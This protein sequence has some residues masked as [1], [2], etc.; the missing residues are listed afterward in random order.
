MRPLLILALALAGGLA[1]GHG[2]APAD[3]PANATPSGNTLQPRLEFASADTELL[4]V[5]Q[6]PHALQIY[7]DDF[8]SNA[9]VDDATLII[10]AGP[11]QRV[12]A[13]AQKAGE[14]LADAEWL[15]G[16]GKLALQL[17]LESPT[18]LE[19]WRGELDLRAP[20]A[21][22]ADIPEHSHRTLL[23]A[24]LL[25]VLLVGTLTWR[26]GR[27]GHGVSVML[28]AGLYLLFPAPPAQAHG[29]A[30]TA[31]SSAGL[32]EGRPQRLA[33][34]SLYLPKASQHLLSLRTEQLSPI[35]ARRIQ[36]LTG[37]IIADPNASGLVMASQAG[38]VLPGPKGLAALGTEV[39]AGDVLAM[40]EPSLSGPERA[41]RASELAALR[42]ELAI[43]ERRVTRFNKLA[44][45]L[46]ALEREEAESQRA[47]L[48]RRVSAIEGSLAGREALTAPVD[49]RVAG[50]EVV[51]G[52]VVEP[53]APLF[54]IQAP[55]KLWVEALA[56]EPDLATRITGAELR[57][58]GRNQTLTLRGIGAR[59]TEQALPLQFSLPQ[60]DAR[61]AVG[62]PVEVLLTLGTLE[63]ALVVSRDALVRDSNGLSVVF[64]KTGAER[65]MTQT[66]NSEPVDGGRVWLKSGVKPGAR[67]V[68]SGASL[69]AQIR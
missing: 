33:D 69:L 43:A 27:R 18:R 41:S 51:A 63:Q 65:F 32:R 60:P 54:S 16:P 52:Q 10:S 48:A 30:L 45:S 7:V 37:R 44:H 55:G 14:Y 35:S 53:G 3:P 42:G 26:L 29:D 58:D 64:I 47:A 40:L 39:K 28:L 17:S 25:A 8:A 9:P 2:D 13:K 68:T 46:P 50:R 31:P 6:A 62:Q 22:S 12:T 24:A 38:R 66:V 49:G 36:R 56:Y 15:S 20:A 67:V 23:L 21:A 4:A 61:L 19:L 1:H 11:G 57:Q 34:G 59:L 5:W